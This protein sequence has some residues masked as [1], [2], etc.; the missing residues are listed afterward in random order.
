MRE[1]GNS[2]YYPGLSDAAWRQIRVAAY[3]YIRIDTR[4]EMAVFALG[5]DAP[6]LLIDLIGILIVTI[7]V[8]MLLVKFVMHVN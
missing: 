8:V 5:I 1:H 7:P 4:V 2:L 6:G 3:Y